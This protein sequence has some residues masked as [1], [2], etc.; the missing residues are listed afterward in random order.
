M[1]C[2]R[3]LE[4]PESK[5]AAIPASMETRCPWSLWVLWSR[6]RG[7]YAVASSRKYCSKVSSDNGP[8]RNVRNASPKPKPN[9]ARSWLPL[10][11]RWVSATLTRL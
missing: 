8:S 4:P 7:G 5:I 9:G 11:M 1:F 6:L 2:L 10:A 3:G